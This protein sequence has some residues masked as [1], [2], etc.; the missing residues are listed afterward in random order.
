MRGTWAPTA[1]DL[2]AHPEKAWR[3]IAEIGDDLGNSLAGTDAA[4]LAEEVEPHAED[5]D[6]LALAP[7]LATQPALVIGATHGGGASNKALADAIPRP[8][9]G[10][11]HQHD[12]RQRPQFRRPPYCAVGRYRRLAAAQGGARRS[13]QESAGS[14]ACGIA[15]GPP[16]L[17]TSLHAS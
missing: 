5:W 4:H 1:R 11:G 17:L 10:E 8:A 7:A 6:L 2:R 9:Q 15:D 3:A 14:L 12:P 13:R 16:V